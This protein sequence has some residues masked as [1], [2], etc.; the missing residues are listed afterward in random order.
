MKKILILL[1]VLF[2]TLQNAFAENLKF[3]QVTDVHLTQENKQYLKDFVNDINKQYSDLDFVVFTGDNIDRAN[4][5]DLATFLD[6]IKELKFKKYVLLGNHDVFKSQHL[7]KK[8]YMKLVKQKLGSYHS[9]KPNYVF[10]DKDVVFIAMDGVK[11]VMPGANG[12]YREDELTWLD[13]QLT[14]YKN[15]K[16]VIF[17][18]FPLID[19][20]VKSHKLYRKEDYLDVLKRH[21][22]VIAIVSG[23]YHQNIEEMQNG[24]YNIVTSK[25]DNNKNYKIIEIDSEIPMVYTQLVSKSE[26]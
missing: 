4:I 25:F 16:V 2:L 21:D 20:S 9:N 24:I 13:N 8:L 5:E 26:D 1:V 14:K 23:H 7:D 15:N 19:S 17:Q 6:T 10:K 11:E 3:I 18:H 22:N 12:Y